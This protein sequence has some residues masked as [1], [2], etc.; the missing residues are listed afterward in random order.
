MAGHATSVA[1][2]GALISVAAGGPL[3]QV[4]DEMSLVMAIMGAL[5]GGCWGVANRRGWRSTARGVVLGALL[6]FGLGVLAPPLMS[7]MLNIEIGPDGGTVQTLAAAAFC[8]G[9]L[10]D[11]LIAWVRARAE[12]S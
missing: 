2:G 12:K 1:A 5:G 7:G 11:V 9:L 8:V 4:F 3:M 10:Q 6:A